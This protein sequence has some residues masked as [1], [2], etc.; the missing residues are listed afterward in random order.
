MHIWHALR[1]CL[2]DMSDGLMELVYVCR[3]SSNYV[4]ALAHVVECRENLEL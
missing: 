2:A 1:G 4:Q 3:R